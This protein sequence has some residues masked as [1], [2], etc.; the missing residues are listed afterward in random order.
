[1]LLVT[2]STILS[3]CRYTV[4]DLNYQ[5]DEFMRPKSGNLFQKLGHNSKSNLSQPDSKDF[6]SAKIGLK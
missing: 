4:D 2:V 5:R 1:M 3:V 6:S